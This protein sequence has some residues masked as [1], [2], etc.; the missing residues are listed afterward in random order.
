V[1]SFNWEEFSQ[2]MFGGPEQPLSGLHVSRAGD[3][4]WPAEKGVEKYPPSAPA[5]SAGQIRA[6][7]RTGEIREVK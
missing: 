3:F 7:L 5:L 2:Q 4:Y 1:S 6:R